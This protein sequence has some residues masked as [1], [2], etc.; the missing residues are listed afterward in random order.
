MVTN[1]FTRHK[2]SNVKCILDAVKIF[3]SQLPRS[4]KMA[5]KHMKHLTDE[6]L[7]NKRGKYTPRATVRSNKNA[8]SIM[9]K[10]L[11]ECGYENTDY[12]TYPVEDLNKVLSK[13]WFSVRK[14]KPTPKKG[15]AGTSIEK[16][17]TDDDLLYSKATLENI[18]HALNRNLQEAGRNIDIITDHEFIESN[19]SY[20]D[21]CKEL[22]AKG[23][24]VVNSY[25]EINHAG[26]KTKIIQI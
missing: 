12:L 19:K 7:A 13:F 17:D 10:Y 4:I 23:K 24:A 14:Q 5:S 9:L 8:N 21:A 11:E 18:R 22:K 26:E 1:H 20:K 6:E 25:P 15:D 16:E 3:A 2:I